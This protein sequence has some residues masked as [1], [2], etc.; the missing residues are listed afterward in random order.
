MA[1]NR[2]GR[3]AAPVPLC[4]DLSAATS[5]GG[6]SKSSATKDCRSRFRN[7]GRSRAPRYV[8]PVHCH[9]AGPRQRAAV[10]Y[11]G[12]RVQGD[13]C[14]SKDVPYKRRTC[15]ERRRTSH[16]PIDV[17]GPDTARPLQGKPMTRMKP[18]PRRPATASSFHCG[19][20]LSLTHDSRMPGRLPGGCRSTP[21]GCATPKCSVSQR[22]N[23][24]LS[25]I[26]DHHISPSH[27]MTLISTL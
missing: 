6:Q 9:R 26:A 4:V 20:D 14:R 11:R 21:S 1:E 25:G 23:G 27:I 3:V 18:P 22:P 17:A 10:K 13:A 7:G 8:I 16:L 15:I 5:R 19:P 2:G 24:P 12:T